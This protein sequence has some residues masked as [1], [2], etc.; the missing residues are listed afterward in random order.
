[1]I[2]YFEEFLNITSLFNM[3]CS[4][5]IVS[6]PRGEELIKIMGVVK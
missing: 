5:V 4:L 1:M 2:V 6:Q 3:S